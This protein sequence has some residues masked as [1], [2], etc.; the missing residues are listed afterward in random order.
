MSNPVRTCVIC[1]KKDLK[2]NL[3]RFSFGEGKILEDKNKKIGRGFYIHPE[4]NLENVDLMQI[5]QRR[6]K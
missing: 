1:R 4:H 3:K 5:W 2:E 6:K